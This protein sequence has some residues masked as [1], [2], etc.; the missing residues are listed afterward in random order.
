MFRARRFVVVVMCLMKIMGVIDMGGERAWYKA[1][2][3]G[4]LGYFSKI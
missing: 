1:M 2:S 4:D 3:L